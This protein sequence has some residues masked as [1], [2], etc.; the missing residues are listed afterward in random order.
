MSELLE[1]PHAAPPAAAIAPAR[2]PVTVYDWAHSHFV[3]KS[4]ELIAQGFQPLSLSVYGDPEDARFAGV[5]DKRPGPPL[6]R[7][8][9]YTINDFL[10]EQTQ[11][12]KQ[13]FYPTLVSATG[14]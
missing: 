7:A 14:G 10:D 3:G 13:G 6:R 2:N 12:Q 11:N 8:I 9:G 5:F 4:D 1:N